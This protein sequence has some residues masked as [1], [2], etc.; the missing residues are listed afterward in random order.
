MMSNRKLHYSYSSELGRHDYIPIM[1]FAY[2][3]VLKFRI[4][5]MYLDFF[6]HPSCHLI[7]S[8][9]YLITWEL[10]LKSSIFLFVD[11]HLACYVLETKS[12]T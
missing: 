3:T 8:H 5:K 9:L 10:Y 6:T 12:S 7:R 2:V 1:L 4:P 11:V